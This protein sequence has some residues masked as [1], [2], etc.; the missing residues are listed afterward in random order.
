[1]AVYTVN[2]SNKN[3][4]RI[5]LLGQFT[6]LRK[7]RKFLKKRLD[8]DFNDAYI[9]RWSLISEIVRGKK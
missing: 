8:D 7:A 4:R 1:M 6:N 9:R 3:R 5:L 2:F